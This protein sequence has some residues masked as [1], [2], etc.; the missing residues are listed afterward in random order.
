M[1][2]ETS[3]AAVQAA[4]GAGTSLELAKIL[5]GITVALDKMNTRIDNLSKK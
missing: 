2:V 3:G 4:Q 5:A 1:V